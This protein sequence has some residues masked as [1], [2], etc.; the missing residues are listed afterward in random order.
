MKFAMSPVFLIVVAIGCAD[1]PNPTPQAASSSESEHVTRNE[2]VDEILK[3]IRSDDESTRIT[4]VES[5]PA[6]IEAQHDH[7]DLTYLV[8]E[9]IPFL[10]DGND[11]IRYWIAMSL[12]K[13]G[14]AAKDSVPD[15]IIALND[16][17]E[18]Y[19]SKSSE[20]GIQFALDKIDP[21]WRSRDDVP[22]AVRKRWGQ[23]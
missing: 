19:A 14:H 9:L 5:L 18:T 13:F 16:M 11:T 3:R 21:N 10:K 20:S 7:D 8:S 12:G 22:D 17:V 1:R 4:A 15:L 2:T 23:K 6:A